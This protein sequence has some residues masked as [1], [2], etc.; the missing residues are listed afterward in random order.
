MERRRFAA[1]TWEVDLAKS[2]EL[3]PSARL[4][5]RSGLYRLEG[6]KYPLVRLDRVYR[7]DKAGATAATRKAQAN[8]KGA[9]ATD[10][11]GGAPAPAASPQPLSGSA[12]LDAG[13][14]ELVWE[15]AMVADHLMVQAQPGVTRE[16]LQAALP[17]GASVLEQVTTRGLYLVGVPSEG[18]RSV[19]RAVLALNEL[20]H[21]VQFAEP[22][23]V[24]SGTDTT[25]NDSLFGSNTS[26]Q[27]WHLGKVM[28]PRAWDV[29]KQPIAATVGGAAKNATEVAN[30]TVV[31]IV[32][33]GV[34]YTHPDLAPNIWLN[35]GESGAG[36]ETNNVD[37]DASGKKDDFRGWNFVEENNNPMDDVGHGTHVAG[38]IGAV[39]NNN[40]VNGQNNTGV[41]GVCWGVKLL[42]LRI[43]KKQ[44]TGTFG[45]YSAAV[46][47]LDYIRKLNETVRKVAVANHSWGGTGYS[48]AMLN[49]IN[50]PV[51][52]PDPLPNNVRSTYI[53][54]VNVLT[55]TGASSDLARIK[56]GM[57]I[58]G[59]GIP[60]GTLV[61]I[62]SG[63]T[64]TLSNYTTLAGSN[65]LL[66]FSNPNRPKPYGVVHVAAAG[67]SRFN[68]DRI[69]TYPASVPSGYVLSVGA[70]D[71]VDAVSIWAG[72]A[73]S[74]FGKLSVD[75]FA[76]GTGIW[77]TKLK[78]AGESNYGY[79]SRN[80]TSMAAPQV[81]GAI[82]LLRLWQPNLTEFAGT[83][84]RDG[85]SG[86]CRCTQGQVRH[87]RTAQSREVC[88]QALPAHSHRQWW[89]DR[90]RCRVIC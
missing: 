84:N 65:V 40:N 36:K 3:P 2:L 81:S 9:A 66:A 37:D 24:L 19:E 29:I 13:G 43:I 46:A 17:R 71:S 68:N 28:A 80:G 47:A 25:P 27:Q 26:T 49:A 52:A 48:L 35:P 54:D 34:D 82:A 79:E 32:D 59:T 51:T 14:G 64:V 69:P 31:A 7:M 16:Q 6:F 53:K 8:T 38:I 39:G 61:T 72:T 58:T 85:S 45:T 44:G 12:V 63:G 33:T 86:T 57:T 21:V 55:A 4:E 41:C 88:R 5:R 87:R 67:N 60:A 73:G 83:A 77:S 89:W 20:T 30:M 42:P 23:F 78:L 1:M 74:N 56:V 76:P 11:V 50:N 22:D 10:P 70:T 18:E 75:L 62:V 15:N 90:R